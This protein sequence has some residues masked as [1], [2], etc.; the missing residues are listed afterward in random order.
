MSE[1]I[2]ISIV[3][4][5]FNEEENLGILYTEIGKALVE[6]VNFEIIMVDDGSQDDTLGVIKRLRTKDSRVKYISFSRN[7]G[8]QFAIK[9]GIDHAVGN[10]VITMDADLQ[11]PPELI[12]SLIDKWEEGYKIVNTKRNDNK[13]Y[14]LSKKLTANLFYSIASWVSE[15]KI[16]E[17]VADFRLMD[18]EVVNL[19]SKIN[20]KFLFLRGLLPW[21]GFKTTTISFDLQN[22]WSGKTKYTFGKMMGLAIN[23]ITSFSIKPLRLSMLVGLI[24]SILSFIYG[25]FAIYA[26][27]FTN[28]AIEGWTSVLVAILFIGGIQLIILGILGE[29]V[30]KIFVQMKDRQ[31]YIVK[32][33]QL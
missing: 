11:H 12:P 15:V 16:E 6:D 30:G 22:R 33:K 18:Q 32:E 29:Y 25:L 19:I 14:S 5:C 24:F 9:A 10:C 2:R 20:D 21:F 27:I 23:G 31:S 28:T 8:H 7:F 13:K 26:R 3:V 1:G 17:G 4:P